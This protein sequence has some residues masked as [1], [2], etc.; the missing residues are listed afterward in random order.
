MAV[1]YKPVLISQ[2]GVKGGGKRKYFAK[3]IA[4]GVT[5]IEKL[6]TYISHASTLG[7]HEV[8]FALNILVE[9]ILLQLLEGNIVRLNSF[10]SLRI[11]I[12]SEGK[13]NKEDV[14]ASCIKEARIVFIPNEKVKRMLKKL[15]YKKKQ[16]KS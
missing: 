10:G 9:Y 2:P 1:E 12:H 8:I 3:A 13:E 5:T 6:A 11:E 7:Y 4:T 15:D 16:E 14:N